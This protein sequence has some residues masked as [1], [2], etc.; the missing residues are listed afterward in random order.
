MKFAALAALAAVSLLGA[1]A[2]ARSHHYDHYRGRSYGSSLQA[3]Y[4]SSRG[5]SVHRPMMA[6]SRPSGATARC[7]DG[8]W[9]FSQNHRGTCSH[10]GGVNAWL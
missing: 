3:Y 9:S 5:N 7:T 1:C 8:S 6:P 4:T 2:E 10:H